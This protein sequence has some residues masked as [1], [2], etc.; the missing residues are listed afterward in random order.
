MDYLVDLGLFYGGGSRNTK[1]LFHVNYWQMLHS[2]PFWLNK[3]FIRTFN[4]CT[5]VENCIAFIIDILM[6]LP[7]QFYQYST[8][9]LNVT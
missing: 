7:I 4:L 3:S 8:Q 9:F 2:I 1:T 6:F 5:V